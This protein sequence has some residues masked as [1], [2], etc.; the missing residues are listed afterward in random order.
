MKKKRD[1]NI[2]L[3]RLLG[4]KIATVFGEDVAF[5][6]AEYARISGASKI[7]IGENESSLSTGA[8]EAEI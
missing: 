3:A 1:E 2:R 5:Q 7:V 8:A 6:I 4:A